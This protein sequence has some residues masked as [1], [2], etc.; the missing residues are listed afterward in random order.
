MV[1]AAWI[2]DPHLDF[3][4]PPLVTRLI[5]EVHQLD[6]DVVL[7]GGDIAEGSLLESMLDQLDWE[8]RK[9]IFFVL[10]NHD[11]YRKSIVTVRR[12]I[13]QKCQGSDTL[14]FL[15][16]SEPVKLNQQTVLIGHDGWADARAGDYA[17]SEVLLNDYWLIQE[18]SGYESEERGKIL[19]RLGDEA[20][21]FTRLHLSKVVDEYRHV[22]FLTHVPPFAE[23]CWHD[24]R[25]SNEQWAPH[26][27]C[28]AVGEVLLEIMDQHPQTRLTV[29]CGHTHSAGETRPRKNIEVITGAARYGDPRVTELFSW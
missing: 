27:T 20:A 14:T 4:E 9:P 26:F 7:I 13:Q 21:E 11:Y 5:D 12:E 19:R 23:A 16:V 6:P 24:G 15:T 8:L 18:L 28:V 22:I 25:A 3:V 29:L 2:T 10:G 17:N 1:R